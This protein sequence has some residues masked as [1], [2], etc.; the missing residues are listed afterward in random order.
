MVWMATGPDKLLPGSS[1]LG[2]ASHRCA[3]LEAPVRICVDAIVPT[4][5]FDMRVG[6]L[7]LE[8]EDGVE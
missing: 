7:M 5:N 8:V 2:E 6:E 1:D 3:Y 4:V